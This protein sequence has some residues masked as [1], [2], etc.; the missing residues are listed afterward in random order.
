[1]VVEIPTTRVVVVDI[2]SDESDDTLVEDQIVADL[3]I[4]IPMDLGLDLALPTR[5]SPEPVI[6]DTAELI[7][8][9]TTYVY[10]IFSYFVCLRFEGF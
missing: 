5:S 10:V 1:M 6:V 7:R 2:D 4:P 3:P 9:P 8:R